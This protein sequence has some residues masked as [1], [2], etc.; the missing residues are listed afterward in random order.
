MAGDGNFLWFWGAGENPT[1]WSGSHY[2]GDE[3]QKYAEGFH[4]K[5]DFTIIQADR[6]IIDTA[7]FS[8]DDLF[9]AL[10][11]RNRA[12]W[13]RG[14]VPAAGDTEKSELEAKLA[15]CLD[16]WLRKHGFDTTTDLSTIRTRDYFPPRK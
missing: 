8:S 2:S 11:L 10:G 16:R 13:P 15:D 9:L 14:V 4:P 1:V 6:Q 5:G 12:C 3:A 7:I